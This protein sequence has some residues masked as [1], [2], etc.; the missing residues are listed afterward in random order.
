MQ[1][2]F[3][4][5]KIFKKRIKLLYNY[6]DNDFPQILTLLGFHKKNKKLNRIHKGFNNQHKEIET[7]IETKLKGN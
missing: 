2:H 6:N 5:N 3:I 1:N 7:K 4:T